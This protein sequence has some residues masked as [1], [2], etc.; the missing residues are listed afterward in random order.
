MGPFEAYRIYLHFI[1][2]KSYVVAMKNKAVANYQLLDC[3]NFQKVERI[4]GVKIVRPAASAIWDK[5]N[6]E[7][8]NDVDWD[9]RRNNNGDGKWVHKTNKKFEN[10]VLQCGPLKLNL[11]PTPFGHVGLFAEQMEYWQKI[12]STCK[13]SQLPEIKVLNLFAYTGGSSIAS[14]LGGASVVHVDASKTSVDW[15]KQNA[16]SNDVDSQAIRWMVDDVTAFV[17]REVRRGNTYQGIILDPPSYGRGPK[18]QL[19]KIEES[20]PLLIEDLKKILADDFLFFHLSAH[21]PG[22]SALALE[23]LLKSYFG[24]ANKFITEE[25]KIMSEYGFTLPSGFSCWMEQ[26]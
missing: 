24:N 13:S 16:L 6:L 20:L 5:S 1:A 14:A 19:W 26:S 8:W 11:K 7:D 22:I 21:T 9:F 10:T 12:I 18:N 4:S 2:D 3:G 17:K 15:A 23:N 25:M